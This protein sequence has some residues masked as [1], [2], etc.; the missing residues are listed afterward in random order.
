MLGTWVDIFISPSISTPG[1]SLMTQ[2]PSD[3]HLKLFQATSDSQKRFQ[4][5]PE[6]NMPAG[7]LEQICWSVFFVFLLSLERSS[8]V[9]STGA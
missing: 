2:I 4:P 5:A 9:T 1:L 3:L 7:S 6:A 8:A